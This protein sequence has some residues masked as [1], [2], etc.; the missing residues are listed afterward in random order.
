[1][2]NVAR[3]VY[4]HVLSRGGYR[5]LVEKMKNERR[6]SRDDSTLDDNGSP[7]PP[8]RHEV[9]KR[10][11]QKKGGEY[12]SKATQVVAEKIVSKI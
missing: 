1:M 4:P 6:L 2:E 12:T 10:A 3:N 9:W 5:L 11:R 8:S 7:S